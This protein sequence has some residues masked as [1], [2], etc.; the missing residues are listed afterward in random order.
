MM[1]YDQAKLLKTYKRYTLAVDNFDNS[2]LPGGSI[3]AMVD[4]PLL[5]KYSGTTRDKWSL[6]HRV[7]V[8]RSE[9]HDQF[10][11]GGDE[12]HCSFVDTLYVQFNFFPG[13]HFERNAHG[14]YFRKAESNRLETLLRA[15]DKRAYAVSRPQ[16]TYWH[17]LSGS[18]KYS[19]SLDHTRQFE[20][21]MDSSPARNL[22]H[23]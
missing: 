23:L 14:Q 6:I 15:L 5:R 21:R 13:E 22:F 16:K 12:G 18:T 17:L 2:T 3:E 8:A 4:L 20:S 19:D 10:Y 11:A 1:L 7:I 9:H